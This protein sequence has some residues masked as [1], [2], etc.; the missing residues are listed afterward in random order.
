[1]DE[2]K[3]KK[4]IEDTIEKHVNGKIDKVYERLDEHINEIQPVI[5]L[6]EGAVVARKVIIWFTSILIGIGSVWLIIKQII[7]R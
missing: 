2:D 3:Q 4:I 6:L 7:G 5:D 1:M